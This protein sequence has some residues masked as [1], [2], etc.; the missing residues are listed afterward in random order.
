TR[1]SRAS[2]LGPGLVPEFIC[3]AAIRTLRSLALEG[4]VELAVAIQRS[5]LRVAAQMPV[6]GKNLRHGSAPMCSLDHRH[7]NFRTLGIHFLVGNTLLI[8]Q[9]F[10]GIAIG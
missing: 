5:N 8:E 10:R 6:T 4:V 9:G 2:R 1:R 3:R 7:A